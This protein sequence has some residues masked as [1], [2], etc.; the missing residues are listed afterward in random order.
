MPGRP[1]L[2]WELLPAAVYSLFELARSDDG[3]SDAQ[4][5]QK[6]ALLGLPALRRQLADDA[7]S[8]RLAL[9]RLCQEV[10]QHG[11][12]LLSAEELDAVRA[13]L[14]LAG[15]LKIRGKDG[16][17]RS[18]TLT[19]VHT[20]RAE[21]AA[22]LVG[23][24]PRMWREARVD[25]ATGVP[26]CVETELLGRFV[27]A[28]AAM[29]PRASTTANVG[30]TSTS[31]PPLLG[32]SAARALDGLGGTWPGATVSDYHL[33]A[34]GPH[35]REGRHPCFMTVDS[36]PDRTRVMWH[37]P[38][39]FAVATALQPA[40]VE[41][42]LRLSVMYESTAAYPGPVPVLS[43]RGAAVLELCD[44]EGAMSLA[45]PYWT[46]RTTSGRLEFRGPPR[47][48]VAGTYEEALAGWAG[49]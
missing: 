42:T 9:I 32:P 44:A 27:H 48:F 24:S 16:S 31:P 18:A 29:E 33:K 23:E 10:E 20:Q 15:A 28:L 26:G 5:G 37:F 46:D 45:G 1:S 47:P 21:V 40:R 4:L 25:P 41:G 2:R 3:A 34:A 6:P 36:S 11:G 35:A 39:G 19:R 38:T 17:Y 30:W 49:T 13:A 7:A 12:G 22:R 43:H 14:R 8:P